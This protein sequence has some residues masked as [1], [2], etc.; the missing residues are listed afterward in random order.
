MMAMRYG[1][2]VAGESIHKLEVAGH[3]RFDKKK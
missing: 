3:Q 2:D 1:H